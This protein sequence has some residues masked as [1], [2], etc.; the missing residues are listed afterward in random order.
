MVAGHVWPGSGSAGANGAGA[1]G[2]LAFGPSA[3]QRAR[4]PN[5]RC[6][7]DADG[8]IL[9]SPFPPLFTSVSGPCIRPVVLLDHESVP[10]F[11]DGSQRL[12]DGLYDRLYI[13]EPPHSETTLHDVQEGDRNEP[14]ARGLGDPARRTVVVTNLPAGQDWRAL[15]SVFCSFGPV[16]ICIITADGGAQ[17][18]FGDAE[19][20]LLAV[21]TYKS[22]N[23]NGHSIVVKLIDPLHRSD[24]TLS[25]RAGR[26][27]LL[28]TNIPSDLHW[29]NLKSAFSVAGRVDVCRVSH[30]RAEIRFRNGSSAQKAMEMY[31]GCDLNGRR[32]AV[33]MFI[34][35]TGQ[36]IVP[37]DP[38]GATFLIRGDRGS[39]PP[40]EEGCIDEDDSGVAAV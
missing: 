9:R 18:T 30:G 21:E 4:S 10:I 29:R 16:E 40:E 24:T 36:V 19:S 25:T 23:L 32:I 13:K 5:G 35:S 15:S 20:A 17:I 31:H 22:S 11:D 14:K 38:P 3:R 26:K 6:W 34:A 7:D 1:T 8:G 39:V 37:D 2:R 33:R 27:T 28:V 12:Y